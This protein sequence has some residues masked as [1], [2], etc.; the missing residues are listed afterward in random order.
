MLKVS[1]GRCRIPLSLVA[2]L[3]ILHIAYSLQWVSY[4]V[5][6]TVWMCQ[7]NVMSRNQWLGGV[8]HSNN[9]QG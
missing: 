6:S 3:V 8:L 9:G 1:R 5:R 4:R 2:I 7:D